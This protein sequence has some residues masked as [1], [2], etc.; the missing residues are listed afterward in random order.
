MGNKRCGAALVGRVALRGFAAR[1]PAM[2]SYE[3]DGTA[4]AVG[5]WILMGLQVQVGAI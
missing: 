2:A 5:C 1:C 3:V 4:L